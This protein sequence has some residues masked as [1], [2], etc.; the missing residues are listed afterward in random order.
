MRW[1]YSGWQRT[2]LGRLWC[3]SRL[4]RVLWDAGRISYHRV[5]AVEE[6]GWIPIKRW[7]ESIK[8][9]W[10][11]NEARQD[12]CWHWNPE[13]KQHWGWSWRLH[14]SRYL[15]ECWGS[16]FRFLTAFTCFVRDR[17]GTVG[18]RWDCWSF[19]RHVS[20]DTLLFSHQTLR[21]WCRWCIWGFTLCFR[22]A[23]CRVGSFMVGLVCWRWTDSFRRVWAYYHQRRRI[24]IRTRNWSFWRV[25]SYW[26]VWGGKRR[27]WILFL[28]QFEDRNGCC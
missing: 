11:C 9:S 15:T 26:W 8:A 20:S 16:C 28:L 13:L 22:E 4:T 14:S 2:L 17:F 1:S 19:R 18:T 10:F 5:G 21:V 24:W 7:T 12:H 27:V 23:T 6:V 25:L 3:D